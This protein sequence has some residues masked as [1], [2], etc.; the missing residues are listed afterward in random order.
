MLIL[1]SGKYII[2]RYWIVA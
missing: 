2:K 1:I